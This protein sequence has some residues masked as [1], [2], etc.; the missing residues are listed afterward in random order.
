MMHGRECARDDVFCI[1]SR[2]RFVALYYWVLLYLFEQ[3]KMVTWVG[4]ETSKCFMMGGIRFAWIRD[5]G[6]NHFVHHCPP[7]YL[8]RLNCKKVMHIQIEL[9]LTWQNIVF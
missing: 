7:K 2:L 3:S 4:A 1:R 6:G 8:R 5:F 9:N